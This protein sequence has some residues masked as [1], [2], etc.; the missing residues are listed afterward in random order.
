MR[1]V[2]KLIGV[3]VGIA[4]VLFV[5]LGVIAHLSPDTDRPNGT[6]GAAAQGAPSTETNSTTSAPDG[7]LDSETKHLKWLGDQFQQRE[8][9]CQQLLK[10][11]YWAKQAPLVADFQADS[12]AVYTVWAKRCARESALGD[13]K[14][15]GLCSTALTFATVGFEQMADVLKNESPMKKETIVDWL[16]K[17][18]N[19][20]QAVRASVHHQIS[21]RDEQERLYSELERSTRYEDQGRDFL[22]RGDYYGSWILLAHSG[23]IKDA[24]FAE[25]LS[26]PSDTTISQGWRSGSRAPQQNVPRKVPMLSDTEAPTRP[27]GASPKVM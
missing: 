21:S 26:P 16:S 27:Y 13:A 24:V 18:P 23:S 15:L 19:E 1:R 17:L 11:P 10:D 14:R 20:R 12:E 6:H 25:T 22:E 7:S 8:E 5:I 4:L 3:S 2:L 9:S